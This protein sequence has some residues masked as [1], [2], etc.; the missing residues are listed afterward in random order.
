MWKWIKSLFKKKPVYVETIKVPLPPGGIQVKYQEMYDSLKMELV[1]RQSVAN[2]NSAV[3]RIIRDRHRYELASEL[4]E[5]SIDKKIPW[6]VIAVI[7]NMESAG[8]FALQI[9]NGQ[10]YKKRTTIVPKNMGPWISWE[11]ACIDAFKIK[12]CPDVWSAGATLDFLEYYNGLG[13]RNMG[14]NSPY[15]WSF[16]QYYKK[17]K[18]TRDHYYD[19]NYISIQVGCAIILKGLGFSG[20]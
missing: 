3:N 9:L 10:D 19:P 1:G 13:Y 2:L 6:E 11:A 12:K 4:V 17:G 14:K 18:Y 8:N 15:L 5:K 20:Q 16:T 7:H